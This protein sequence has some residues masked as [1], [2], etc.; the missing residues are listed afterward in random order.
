MQEL[1]FNAST[2]KMEMHKRTLYALP[3]WM[4]VV[5][6]KEV[7]SNLIENAIKY[8]GE[9]KAVWVKSWDDKDWV[10]IEVRDNGSEYQK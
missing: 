9:G 7:I 4:D 10:Y 3:H 6:T 2:K 1:R 8:A 5:L